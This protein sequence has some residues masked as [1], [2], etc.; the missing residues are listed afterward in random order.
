M[1][2]TGAIFILGVSQRSGTNYLA[3]LLKKE[4]GKTFTDLVTE[5][6][7]EKAQELLAH[8]TLR[9]AEVAEAVGFEDEAYFARRFRQCLKIAPR[10]YRNRHYSGTDH[11]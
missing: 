8:T 2:S 4:T 5:R 3:H 1:T 11:R 7:M 9:I 10:E 6:R